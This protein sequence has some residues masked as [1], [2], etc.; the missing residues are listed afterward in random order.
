MK[1]L[2]SPKDEL[3]S[4]SYMDILKEIKKYPFQL[5][6]KLM[7]E[8]VY[9]QNF[10]YKFLRI[11]D[12]IFPKN[13]VFLANSFIQEY[14]FQKLMES[15]INLEIRSY[16]EDTEK[17]F[18]GTY[19]KNLFKRLKKAKYPVTMNDFDEKDIVNVDV[20]KVMWILLKFTQE[21]LKDMG[22]SDV[23]KAATKDLRDKSVDVE[24][25]TMDGELT[26]AMKQLGLDLTTGKSFMNTPQS[27]GFSQNKQ[28]NDIK[29]TK[30]KSANINEKVSNM[31]E[32]NTLNSFDD[33]ND[34]CYKVSDGRVAIL[35]PVDTP[36]ETVEI[37]GMQ[38]MKF[39][40][41]VPDL[42]TDS[43]Q[44]KK[45]YSEVLNEPIKHD[46]DFIRVPIFLSNSDENFSES[47]DKSTENVENCFEIESLR[48]KKQELDKEIAAARKSG[49]TD[50]VNELRKQRRKIRNTINKLTKEQNN[51]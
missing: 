50:L 21:E 12:L 29:V 22:L 7:N 38:F 39:V 30:K 26:K 45:I 37:D 18:S 48:T 15:N 10:V 16:E 35:I 36:V 23:I 4:V 8:L 28:N 9:N 27:Q 42:N 40:T 49:D 33:E 43:L 14:T 13:T 51:G 34:L 32:K 24:E 17:Y 6:S 46:E 1:I 19:Y 47:E 20:T 5:Q 44:I 41:D 2:L 11:L 3:C 31:T 25:S